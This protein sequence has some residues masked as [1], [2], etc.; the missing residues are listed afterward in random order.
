MD[1]DWVCGENMD[2][3]KYDN[4][5]DFAYVVVGKYKDGTRANLG[6]YLTLEE[7]G[8]SENFWLKLNKDESRHD[9]DFDPEKDTLIGF[10]VE[11]LEFMGLLDRRLT[12]E[13]PSQNQ[14]IWDGHGLTVDGGKRADTLMPMLLGV[15]NNPAIDMA[16]AKAALDEAMAQISLDSC[17]SLNYDTILNRKWKP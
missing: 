16:V 2:D 14:H 5:V 15:L 7:A 4:I 3:K 6:L 12:I 8:E 10:E 11:V 17:R 13:Q 9:P 1:E